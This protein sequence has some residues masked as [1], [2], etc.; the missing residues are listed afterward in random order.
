MP[1]LEIFKIASYSYNS[2][3]PIPLKSFKREFYVLNLK[4][5][6]ASTVSVDTLT[7]KLIKRTFLGS[8]SSTQFSTYSYQNDLGETLLNL[9]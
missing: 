3:V 2:S 7:R 9:C 6:I 1:Y 5:L 8:L 4:T